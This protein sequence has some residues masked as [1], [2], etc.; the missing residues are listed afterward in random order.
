MWASGWELGKGHSTLELQQSQI[1]SP[2]ATDFL[3]LYILS[4]E[5]QSKLFHSL[6]IN[7]G[8]SA[9]GKVTLFIKM[10]LWTPKK[11]KKSCSTMVICIQRKKNH[12]VCTAWSLKR[13][14]THTP[15]NWV[16]SVYISSV[17]P[18]LHPT[19][20]LGEKA[21]S[22][23]LEFCRQERLKTV[24]ADKTKTCIWAFEKPAC[25]YTPRGYAGLV[26]LFW[27]PLPLWTS[28]ATIMCHTTTIL[29]WTRRHK[30]CR[31]GA[32]SQAGHCWHHLPRLFLVCIL[33]TPRA[34][35]GE[36]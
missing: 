32:P 11:K 1:A 2:L 12:Q 27:I 30:Y 9:S 34:Y 3:S 35:R 33:S 16:F 13:W 26:C 20:L 15:S 19:L 4:P 10:P 22:T 8:L 17:L 29:S 31:R 28:N 7:P 18:S 25:F 5:G 23:Q 24:I 21:S 36:F 6:L 14:G